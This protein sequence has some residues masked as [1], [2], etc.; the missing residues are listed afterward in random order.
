MEKSIEKEARKLHK[1]LVNEII[2][3]C[4]EHEL[5]DIDVVILSMD[6]LN[7]S[8][9]NGTW[10]GGTDSSMTFIDT[11]EDTIIESI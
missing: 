11:N 7:Y 5:Y 4:N 9:E 8:I 2:D 3:F 10:M 6:G 1:K